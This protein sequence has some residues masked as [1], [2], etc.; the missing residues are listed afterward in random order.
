MYNVNGSALCFKSTWLLWNNLRN[1][2]GTTHLAIFGGNVFRVGS[3]FWEGYGKK[4]MSVSCDCIFARPAGD[5][6][7]RSFVVFCLLKPWR[8]KH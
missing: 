1:S 8:E 2:N 6:I 7:I 4:N 3:C 5:F